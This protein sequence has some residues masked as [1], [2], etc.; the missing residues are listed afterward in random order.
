MTRLFPPR[1]T[2]RLR[3]ALTGLV[4]ALAGGLGLPA[5]AQTPPQTPAP[6]Q[7]RPDQPTTHAWPA[8]WRDA[9]QQARVPASAVSVWVAPADGG[10]PRIAHAADE[11]RRMASLMK[12]FTTGAALQQ[13]GTAYTWR[14]DAGLGAALGA[15]GRLVGP[16]HL[17][18]S[19]DPALVVERLQWLLT[20]WRQAGLRHLEGD[21]VVDRSVF[22]RPAH[23]PAAFDGQALRPYNAGA[24]PLLLN[25]QAVM[26]ML[27]PGAQGGWEGSLEPALSGVRVELK[28][29][30]APAAPAASPAAFT[31]AGAASADCAAGR[32]GLQL[33]VR[34]K[35]A[36]RGDAVT[37]PFTGP[38]RDWT[39]IVQGALHPACGELTWPLLWQGDGPGDHAE[40]LL[41]ATWTQLGGTWNGRLRGG[42][43]PAGL[44]V[45]RS[46][47]SPPLGQVV[48]DINKYSNNVMARQL[49]LTLPQRPETTLFSARAHLVQAVQARVPGGECAAGTLVVDNGAGLSRTEGSTARCMGAWLAQLWRSPE[50]PDFMASL[51]L[52]AVDG[53]TRRWTGAAGHAHV[54]TGSLDGVTGVAG[55]VL[56]RSG[57]RHVVVAV[58]DHPQAGQARAWLNAVLEWARE[59]AP[60]SWAAHSPPDQN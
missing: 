7:M 22:V 36:V 52:T 5:P 50:M 51:P 18:A 14:T 16:L 2:P 60:A 37:G 39:L 30:S 44:P 28:L 34:P 38:L 57:Q 21:I 1:S 3:L 59:D 8:A 58:V 45:W 48:R 47:S 20:Q 25:H 19:G 41:R 15:D 31:A 13:L 33:Q 40:R 12:L 49:L 42:D 46:L 10:P 43:W 56:G 27:R 11:L 23:D 17:R 53:T 55:Y 6:P 32:A 9:L 26:L 54:K 4:A 24:D 35:D 29:A